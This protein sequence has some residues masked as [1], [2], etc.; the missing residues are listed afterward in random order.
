M[1]EVFIIIFLALGLF[2]VLRHYPEAKSLGSGEK[3]TSN[4]FRN[5]FAKIPR[6]LENRSRGKDAVTVDPLPEVNIVN[7]PKRFSDLSPEVVEKLELAEEALVKNDL[8]EV[9]EKALEAISLNK[10]C[11]EAYLL[12]AKVAYTRGQFDDARD[13]LKVAMKCNKELAEV[14]FYLGLVEA[15]TGNN[16]KAVENLER[17]TIFEKGHADWYCELGKAYNEVRQFS[18]AAKVFKKAASLDIENDEYKTLATEAESKI[19]SHSSY[20]RMR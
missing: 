14:Y 6:S 10:R 18:K 4:N 5:L 17:A 9:E 3:N 8:R 13:A 2:M 20:F 11:G 19:R 7:A 12:M 15:R 16:S 1:L